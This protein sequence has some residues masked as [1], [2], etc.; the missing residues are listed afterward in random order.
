MLRFLPF[1]LDRAVLVKVLHLRPHHLAGIILYRFCQADCHLVGVAQFAESSEKSYGGEARFLA[2]AFHGKG[3]I[4]FA[5]VLS[6][7][8][9][10]RKFVAQLLSGGV[11]AVGLLVL[12]LLLSLARSVGC[13]CPLE[14]AKSGDVAVNGFLFILVC[15][16]HCGI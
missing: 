5:V 8:V 13:V 9:S 11:E 7:F 3:G 4:R 1:L 2:C 10:V 6:R 15:C 12:F 16:F 14:V